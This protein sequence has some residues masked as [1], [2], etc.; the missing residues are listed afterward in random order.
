MSSDATSPSLRW[1]PPQPIEPT[2]PPTAT[3]TKQSLITNFVTATLQEPVVN[4]E[5]RVVV[6]LFDNDGTALEPWL[7]KGYTCVSYQHTDNPRKHKTRT[8]NGGSVTVCD[9]HS[10]QALTGIMMKHLD[11]VAFACAMPPSK[12]LSVAGARHWK[13]KRDK[14]P[15]FQEKAVELIKWV[16]SLFTA[17]GCPY[18]IANPA[19][20]QLGKLMRAPNHTYQ[21][22]QFGGYLHE[23]DTHPL[24]PEYIP[25]Q[26]AYTQHQGLWTGGGLRMPV[27][28]PVTP[29]WKYFVSKRKGAR[30]AP[31]GMR[32]MSPILYSNWNARGA[33]ACTPRGFAIALCDRLHARSV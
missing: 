5:R 9:L 20:S 10:A 11:T 22:Y 19:T 18:Y 31:A 2:E 1:R 29:T 8:Y 21:P 23:S 4:G 14:D 3:G 25:A 12:D 26:D 6:S 28:K 27:P 15:Q 16:E 30:R 24:Y 17:W 33:R 32:R 7:R 13:R